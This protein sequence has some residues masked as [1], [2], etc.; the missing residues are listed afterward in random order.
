MSGGGRRIFGEPVMLKEWDRE[1]EAAGASEFWELFLDL[2]LVA[3]ASSI[4]DQMKEDKD[5]NQFAVFYFI[6]V[7]GWLFYT[8]HIT[9]RFE[10]NSLAHAGV[11]FLYIVGFALSMVYVSFERADAFALGAILQRASILIMLLNI[12]VCVPFARL[13][14]ATV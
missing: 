3:A 5:Y 9:C 11:L 2:L 12:A 4:S 6:I 7:N 10:D 1:S 8:H 14:C 13:F